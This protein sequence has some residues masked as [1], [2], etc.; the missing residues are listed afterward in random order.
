M[1]AGFVMSDKSGHEGSSLRD[2][3]LFECLSGRDH[4]EVNWDCV[5]GEFAGDP[6]QGIS[7]FES[8]RELALLRSDLFGGKVVGALTTTFLCGTRECDGDEGS[9]WA[10]NGR[11]GQKNECEGCV[12]SLKEVQ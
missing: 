11:K 7:A 10:E 3:A 12:V 9:C 4:I 5:V 1:R 6:R 8:V 2:V